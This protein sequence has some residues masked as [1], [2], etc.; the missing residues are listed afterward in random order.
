MCPHLWWVFE[1]GCSDAPKKTGRPFAG[2]SQGKAPR[3][4]TELRS[5]A[6]PGT[7]A[8][9]MEFSRGP[10]PKWLVYINPQMMS[11][12]KG[13]GT[14]SNSFPNEGAPQIDGFLVANLKTTPQ[15]KTDPKADLGQQE[16][17]WAWRAMG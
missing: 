9:S 4:E 12:K 6:S 11:Q 2:P 1:V 16:E 7:Q 5:F 17:P 15:Q 8:K 10:P 3:I 14:L 13:S